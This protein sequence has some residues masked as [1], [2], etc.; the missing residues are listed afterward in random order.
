MYSFLFRNRYTINKI[1]LIAAPIILEVGI[2]LLAKHKERKL[3]KIKEV[4]Y[5]N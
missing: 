5:G 1:I 4:N 2:N 3:S